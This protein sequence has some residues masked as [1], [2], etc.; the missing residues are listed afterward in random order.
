MTVW[1]AL[2]Y[3]KENIAG[4]THCITRLRF[5]L[6]DESK[7]NTDVLKATD[8]VVT[9]IQSGGQYQVVIGNQVSEVYDAVCEK[10]HLADMTSES[11]DTKKKGLGANGG[12]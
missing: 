4:L 8:G 1:P 5:Q 12:T 2:S 3:G 9:V 7:A 6:K 10:A 11:E